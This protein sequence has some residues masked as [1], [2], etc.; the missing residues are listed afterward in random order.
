MRGRTFRAYEA[1]G[2]GHRC[3]FTSMAELRR[4]QHSCWFQICSIVST[5]NGGAMEQDAPYVERLAS[6]FRRS[7]SP[8]PNSAMGPKLQDTASDKMLGS[9]HSSR[10]SANGGSCCTVDTPLLRALD[11]GTAIA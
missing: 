11:L 3:S 2:S 6:A 10:R 5:G 1:G 9:W 7:T 8:R 4:L